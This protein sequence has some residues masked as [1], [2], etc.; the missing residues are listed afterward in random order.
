MSRLSFQMG[1]A[2]PSGGI[3]LLCIVGVCMPLV[4]AV[5]YLSSRGHPRNYMSCIKLFPHRWPQAKLWTFLP[6]QLVS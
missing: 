5:I 3:L 2:L 4:I 6:R 1:I